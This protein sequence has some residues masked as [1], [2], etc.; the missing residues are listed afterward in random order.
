MPFNAGEKQ[1][2]IAIIDERV[3]DRFIRY[4]EATREFFDERVQG[5]GELI[6]QNTEKLD[7]VARTQQGHTEMIG[8]LAIDMT[9]VKAEIKDMKKEMKEM[10]KELK[11]K[12]DKTD[13]RAKANTADFKALDRRIVALEAA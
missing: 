13:L 7:R 9:V 4:M 2:I 1:E 3:E 5:V 10:N 11:L 6:L 12:A 8:S